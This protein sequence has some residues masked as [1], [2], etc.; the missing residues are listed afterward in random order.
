MWISFFA[1]PKTIPSGEI[2]LYVLYQQLLLIIAREKSSGQCEKSRGPL[3]I[4]YGLEPSSRAAGSSVE[5]PGAGYSE[6]L[7]SQDTFFSL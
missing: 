2:L 5:G 3:I 4:Y 6:K 7:L 1:L